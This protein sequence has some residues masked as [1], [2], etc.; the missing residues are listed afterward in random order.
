MPSDTITAFPLLAFKQVLIYYQLSALLRMCGQSIAP[1][2]IPITNIYLI[3]SPPAPIP[4]PRSSRSGRHPDV[5]RERP[6]PGRAIAAAG[7]AVWHDEMRLAALPLGRGRGHARE[8]AR[9]ALPN[10]PAL[11]TMDHSRDAPMP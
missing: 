7:D 3:A 5:H 10:R 6:S 11:D 1:H 2:A 4:R 8:S 9:A